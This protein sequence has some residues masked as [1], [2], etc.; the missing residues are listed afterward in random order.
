MIHKNFFIYLSDQYKTLR[1]DYLIYLS[2]QTTYLSLVVAF[3]ILY[4]RVHILN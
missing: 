1:N 3:E 4:P 2:K